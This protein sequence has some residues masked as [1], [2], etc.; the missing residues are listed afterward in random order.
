MYCV[1]YTSP[2]SRA[3]GSS[4]FVHL[5]ILLAL[6]TNYQSLFVFVEFSSGLSSHKYCHLLRPPLSRPSTR[7][8][9]DIWTLEA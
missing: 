2:M 4:F 1:D 7:P 9:I 3:A 8:E 5:I 6:L